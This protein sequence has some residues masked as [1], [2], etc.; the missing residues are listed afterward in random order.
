[1]YI[2]TR[3]AQY[4]KSLWKLLKKDNTFIYM[5]G[6]KG[7]EKGID[8]IM[9]SLAVRDGIVWTD[10]KKSLKKAGQGNVEVH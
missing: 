6:L 4:A 9:D 2:H 10:F 7:M 1:M 3:M 5:C 8:E